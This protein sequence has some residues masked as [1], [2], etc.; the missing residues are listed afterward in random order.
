[1]ESGTTFCLASAATWWCYEDPAKY[2]GTSRID[3]R[4]F[5]RPDGLSSYEQMRHTRPAGKLGTLVYEPL[6]ERLSITT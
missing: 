1:M 5:R 2:F 6:L 4:L 3:D